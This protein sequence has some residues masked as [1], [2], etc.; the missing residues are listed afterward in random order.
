[1]LGILKNATEGNESAA[2][3]LGDLAQEGARRMLM[4]A[5]VRSLPKPRP[6]ALC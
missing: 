2:S 1:M 6:W 5:L 4:S 3:S